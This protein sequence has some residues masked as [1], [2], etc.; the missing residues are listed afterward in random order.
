M[1]LADARWRDQNAVRAQPR[2]DIAVRR[3]DEIFLKQRPAHALTIE[4]R[5]SRSVQRGAVMRRPSKI[6]TAGRRLPLSLRERADEQP[7]RSR[8]EGTA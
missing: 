4:P 3:R 6:L 1:A 2:G 7:Y 5:K 8:G